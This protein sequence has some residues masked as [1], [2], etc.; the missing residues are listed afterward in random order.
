MGTPGRLSLWGLRVSH[1]LA[2]EQQQPTWFYPRRRRRA[3]R[4][5]G[6]GRRAAMPG[7]PQ[8]PTPAQTE[9]GTPRHKGGRWPHRAAPAK[10]AVSQGFDLC[11]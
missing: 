5:A 3:E 11:C 7:W 6:H 1:D 4:P 8:I 9:A 2:T 10:P